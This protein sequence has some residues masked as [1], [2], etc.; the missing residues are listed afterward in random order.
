MTQDH[1]IAPK[2]E[3]EITSTNNIGF[4]FKRLSYTLYVAK[5]VIVKIFPIHLPMKLD[6]ENEPPLGFDVDVD[7]KRFDLLFFNFLYKD[8][9][10]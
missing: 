1:N 10:R 8:H 2:S 6:S 3:F 9:M 5:S 4:L 7:V